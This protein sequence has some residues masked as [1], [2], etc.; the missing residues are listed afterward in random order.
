MALKTNFPALHQR[1]DSQIKQ[2]VGY[3]AHRMRTGDQIKHGL[4]DDH[5]TLSSRVVNR[6]D[7]RCRAIY[8]EEI[9][10]LFDQAENLSGKRL[11]VFEEFEQDGRTH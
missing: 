3:Q 1:T 5:R 6:H 2:A 11:V 7:F 4:T 10:L 8:R 9:L